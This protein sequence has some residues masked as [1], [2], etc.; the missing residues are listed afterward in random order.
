MIRGLY[1][2]AAG[3][4]TGLMRHETIVHNL[5]NV[6]TVGYKADQ[7]TLKDFPSLLLA[8]TRDGESVA[9]IGEMGTGVS[10][11]SVTTDYSDGPLKLTDHPLDVAIVGDGFFRVETPDGIRYTRDGRFHRDT[12][13]QLITAEGYRVLGTAGP[14]TLPEGE[15]TITPQ[16]TLFV[17]DNQIGELSIARF[18]DLTQVIKTGQTLFNSQGP[19]PELMAANEVRVYQG[20]VEESNVDVAQA[21]TEMTAVLRAY[22][23]SQRLVQFQDQINK[24]SVNELGRV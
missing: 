12:D 22:Q 10:L 11:D 8:E 20:Y 5:A 21:V 1:T 13:G 7:A 16:G 24:Q 3:M 17:N 6:R 23:A 15:L 9:R 19:E 4:L 2:V 18:N 14:L